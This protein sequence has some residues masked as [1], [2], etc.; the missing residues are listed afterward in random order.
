MPIKQYRPV[1]KGRRLSSV[2]DFSDIT[3]SKPEKSLIRVRKQFAGRTGGK[4]T[5]RHKGAGNKRF[6]RE[7]DF[8]RN[9]FDI[10][11]KVVSV[12]YD[13]NR[14]ARIGM[15]VYRDGVKSYILLPDGL[16]AGDIIVSSQKE[17]EISVG[18]R[19]P[20]EK[21][22]VGTFIHAVEITPGVGAQLARGAGNYIEFMA[23]EGDSATLKLPSGEVR[24]VPKACMATI[25]MVSNPDWHLIRWGKAGRMRHRGIRPT[26]RGKVMN[27]VDHPHGGGEGKHP[28]GMPF[29]KT[30]W[31]K[32][33]MG[34]KTRRKH[35]ASD[36]AILTRRHGNILK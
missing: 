31:G 11:A 10:P 12:E 27:P 30:K 8:I 13:P 4:I 5:V 34:V 25:G 15:I 28:I 16:K 22:P 18:N 26:V 3:R 1:T 23:V 19:L 35:R 32:H 24:R 7:V 20:L 33:A 17:A 36:R 29:A 9:R 6:L 2:Q 21:I 14:G